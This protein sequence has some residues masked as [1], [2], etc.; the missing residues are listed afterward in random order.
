MGGKRTLILLRPRIQ[1]EEFAAAVEARFPEVFAPIVAPLISIVP[2]PALEPIDLSSVQALL[3]TSV[4]GVEAF[5]SL[6]S[7][8]SL[9]AL[10][11]G[12]MTAMAASRLGFRAESAGGDVM[13]LAALAVASRVPVGGRMLHVRGRHA[14]G[15]LLQE[16]G[17]AGIEAGAI[18]VYDQVAVPLA[19]EVARVL[20]A[21]EDAIV[22]A[23]SPR[24]ARLF[25]D[26]VVKRNLPLSR[27]ATL[28][29][30]AAADHP[31]QSLGFGRRVVAAAPTREA[32]LAGLRQLVD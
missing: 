2:V 26:E 20:A 17:S 28:A 30:S 6:C 22:T 21:G 19:D 10:C 11:V 31:L 25:A 12:E 13:S 4:N 9:L 5:A 18:E 27:A 15:N 16:L 23:F 24:S 32:M 8:R 29:L 14:A 7:D 3:F 1:A